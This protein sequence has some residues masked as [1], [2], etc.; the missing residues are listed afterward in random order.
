MP[1]LTGCA[2]MQRTWKYQGAPTQD[3]IFKVEVVEALVKQK[4]AYVTLKVT[5]LT[6]EAHS[7]ELEVLQ[8]ILPDGTELPA[9]SNL[10]GRM[11]TSVTSTVSSWFG[12]ESD[13]APKLPAGEVLEVKFGIRHPR[14]DLRRQEAIRIKFQG[15]IVDG[16]PSTLPDMILKAPAGAPTSEWI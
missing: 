14:K 3:A 9:K 15:M 6:S 13:D 2:A 4:A 16:K 11:V 12:G 5:N 8:V 10:A 1:L 7:V